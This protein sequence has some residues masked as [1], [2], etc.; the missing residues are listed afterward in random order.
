M[1][2]RFPAVLTALTLLGAH[3]TAA[4]SAQA[5]SIQVSGLYNAVFGD[6]FETLKNG[7]GGEAQLRY[8]PG[9]LSFGLGFQYTVHDRP[10]VDP[11]EPAL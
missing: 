7:F 10:P 4:Q 11:Q 3:K 1:Y 6:V 2:R 5:V 8:T 9:A